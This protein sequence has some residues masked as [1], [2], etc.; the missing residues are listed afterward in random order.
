MGE[1]NEIREPL[2]KEN[3]LGILEPKTLLQ[4]ASEYKVS[5]ETMRSWLEPFKDAIGERQG[6]IFKINQVRL[7]YDKLGT[8]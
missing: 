7:I 8:P 2:R 4:L 6:N 3:G 5:K 1:S